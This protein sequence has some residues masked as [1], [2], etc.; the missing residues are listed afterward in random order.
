LELPPASNYW[1]LYS[2]IEDYELKGS[3]TIIMLLQQFIDIMLIDITH[4][5]NY[6]VEK[7]VARG[8]IGEISSNVVACVSGSI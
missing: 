4:Q 6:P 5:V 2:R 1:E 8:I 3:I 7:C